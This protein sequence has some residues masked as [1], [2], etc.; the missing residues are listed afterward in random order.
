MSALISCTCENRHLVST[1]SRVVILRLAPT[2]NDSW[3]QP[4]DKWQ[5]LNRAASYIAKYGWTVRRNSNTTNDFPMR[6]G[7]FPS[8]NV[9]SCVPQHV[10]F[11]TVETFLLQRD[12]QSRIKNEMYVTRLRYRFIYYAKKLYFRVSNRNVFQKNA[13]DA[14]RA[15]VSYQIRLAFRYNIIAISQPS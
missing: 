2:T 10:Y 9:P 14:Y 7:T 11:H 15:D 8:W 6:N 1:L 5:S 4:N 13:G 12:V 3:R